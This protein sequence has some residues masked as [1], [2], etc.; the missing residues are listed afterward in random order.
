MGHRWQLP[1]CP[2]QVRQEGNK[3]A[4]LASLKGWLGDAGKVDNKKGKNKKGRGVRMVYRTYT[5]NRGGII[6]E[7][8]ALTKKTIEIQDVRIDAGLLK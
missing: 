3:S 2:A 6:R 7:M 4:R 8:Y 1:I 5:Y